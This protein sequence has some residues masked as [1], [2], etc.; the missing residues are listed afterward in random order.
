VTAFCEDG[1]EPPSSIYCW[2]F[3]HYLS[4]AIFSKWTV[5]CAVNQ[6][7]ART[8]SQAQ[9]ERCWQ[10]CY[11][12]G[13][14]IACCSCCCWSD[15]SH[16]DRLSGHPA[17]YRRDN[18]ALSPVNTVPDQLWGPPRLSEGHSSVSEPREL[19]HTANALSGS[20]A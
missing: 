14:S 9:I 1:A 12:E 3:V 20:C 11:T 19:P 7:V 17:S 5:T 18:G 6:N 16:A 2:K 8:A 13:P 10:A 4:N 15:A